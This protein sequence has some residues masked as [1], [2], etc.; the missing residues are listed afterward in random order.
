MLAKIDAAK[1]RRD[2][3]SLCA[4][5]GSRTN[6]PRVF[7]RCAEALCDVCC[8]DDP[9]RVAAV[10]QGAI[11]HVLEALRRTSILQLASVH[12]WA[13]L[14]LL[15]FKN[16]AAIAQ[17]V[18]GGGPELALSCLKASEDAETLNF[19]VKVVCS[20]TND[21][22]HASRA[23]SLGIVEVSCPARK[24]CVDHARRPYL[25]THESTSRTSVF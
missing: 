24:G 9:A 1:E 13:L 14:A 23:V 3:V 15:L 17:A 19:A 20:V 10:A 8:D 18:D 21:G 2:V 22:G 5:L 7:A 16:S 25:R 6:T 11:G 12:G 4:T